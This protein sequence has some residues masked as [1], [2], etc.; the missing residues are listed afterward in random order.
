M[1]NKLLLFCLSMIIMSCSSVKKTQQA[2]NYGNYDE[3]ISIALKHLKDNKTKKSNQTYVVLLEDAFSKAST[4]NLKRIKYLKKEKNPENL[5]SIFNTYL[6]LKNR[7]EKIKPL[8]PL[9][10][11]INGKIA[12]FHFNDYSANIITQKNKLSNY[13]Y[14]KAN[15]ELSHAR[16]KYDYRKVFDDLSSLEKI[17]SNYKNTRLLLKE[18]HFKGTNFVLVTVQN[19]SDKILPKSLAYDLLNFNTYK[20]NDFW[21]VYQ[22]HKNLNTNYNFRLNINL[23][24][25]NISPEQI[26]E[27][28]IIIEKEVKDGF[29]FLVDKKGHFVKDSLGNKIKVDKFKKIKIHLDKFSQFKSVQIVGIVNYYNLDNQQLIQSF[30]LSSEFIFENHYATSSG[31]KA[32]LNKNYLKLIAAKPVPFPRNEQMIYDSSK[33]LKNKIKNIITHHKFN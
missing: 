21:T 18:S 16:N 32:A 5:E 27:K 29:K 2:I 13:L 25:I 28:Q 17:N 4:K 24:K 8:L 23:R 14:N 12:K 10:N 26:K 33:D 6:L 3:A 7:Q 22:S 31:N 15:F 19:T 20:L 1:K 11:Q 9:K 30:P